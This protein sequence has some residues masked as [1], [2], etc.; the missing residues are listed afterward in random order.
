MGLEWES[1]IESTTKWLIFPEYPIPEGYNH[2]MVKAALEIPSAY[3][4]VQI[5]MVFFYPALALTKGRQI[6]SISFRPIDGNQYQQ[7]S[8]HRNNGEWRPGLDNVCM[9]LL[10]VENWLKKE[11]MK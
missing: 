11:L 1:I 6:S 7:W 2:R 3:P 4:D 10:M 8:R 5:D 9:H